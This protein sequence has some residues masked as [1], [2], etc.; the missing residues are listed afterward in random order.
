MFSVAFKNKL[1]VNSEPQR[2]F[3]ITK[4]K[5]QTGCCSFPC[6]IFCLCKPN[7]AWIYTFKIFRFSTKVVNVKSMQAFI[8]SH[9]SEKEIFFNELIIKMFLARYSVDI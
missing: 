9:L 2:L 8:G 6:Q 3:F 5:W 4:P 7:Y 1:L